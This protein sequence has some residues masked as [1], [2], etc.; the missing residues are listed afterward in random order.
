[1]ASPDSAVCAAPEDVDHPPWHIRIG[2]DTAEQVRE[3]HRSS[4]V[5]SKGG[6]DLACRKP[7]EGANHLAAAALLTRHTD[8]GWRSSSGSSDGPSTASMRAVSAR[9]NCTNP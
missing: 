6:G 8:A 4:Q 1:M 5:D 7:A 3:R 9:S 2:K